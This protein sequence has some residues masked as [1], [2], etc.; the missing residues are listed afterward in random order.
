ME[1]QLSDLEGL[2]GLRPLGLGHG[3]VCPEG[4]CPSGGA[5]KRA[6]PVF[7]LS[8]PASTLPG[9]PLPTSTPV[10]TPV[11]TTTGSSALSS[12]IAGPLAPG[13]LQS[14]KTPKGPE[15]DGSIEVCDPQANPAL[16]AIEA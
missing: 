12:L 14:L 3:P 16:K 4:V 11:P 2:S 8:T 5:L 10:P 13:L 7:T 15:C 1:R 6:D 9:T